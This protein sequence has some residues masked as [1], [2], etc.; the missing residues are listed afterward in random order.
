MLKTMASCHLDLKYWAV[1]SLDKCLATDGQ[2][3]DSDRLI[4]IGSSR[5][6]Q[7]FVPPGGRIIQWDIPRPD[8][9]RES[10]ID[11]ARDQIQKQVRALA[12]F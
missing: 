10:S 2:L 3:R 9:D 7:N 11:G 4:F 1:R 8:M 12:G 6:I 5:E